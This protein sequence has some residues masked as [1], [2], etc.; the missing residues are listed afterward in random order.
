[1]GRQADGRLGGGILEFIC[2]LCGAAN[3]RV[4]GFGREEPSCVTCASNVR[5]RGLLR[6]LS[7]E[8]F[9]MPLT[10]PDFPR[11]KSL[12]GIGMSDSAQYADLL[13]ARF[14][15]RNT[16]YD[17]EPRFD[18]ANVD[19]REL[20]LHDFVLSSEVLEH[21]APP[22]GRSLAN[23]FGL[24]KTAGVLLLTVPYSLE[25]TTAEH[26]PELGEYGV[27]RV[28][29]RLVLV[30]RTRSGE[31]QVFDELVFHVS[32]GDPALEAREF[33]QRDLE[34]LLRAAGFS[35]VRI[36]SEEYRPY[37]I[38]HA[39]QCSFPIAARKGAFALGRDA[40]R[41]VVEQ[42]RDVRQT[43]DRQMQRL[44][45]SYWFRIGRK[46]GFF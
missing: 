38:V 37:G 22:V 33:S 44:A 10:V 11:V 31:T 34:C 20:G 17:R 28:G 4:E 26:F 30:N 35:E 46:L 18:I 15:Y 14:D 6:A 21:V 23:A 13:A 7:M 39:E 42:W 41:D 9:G 43:H 12:R 29:E 8:L 25:A 3:R 24:L 36:Y 45:Q 5:M 2:N 40:T 32:F 1:M 19:E 27:A 16:F